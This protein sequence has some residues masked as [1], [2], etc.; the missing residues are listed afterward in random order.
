MATQGT[1]NVMV[2]KLGIAILR[3]SSEDL[4]KGIRYLADCAV[5]VLGA[6]IERNDPVEVIDTTI[7]MMARDLVDASYAV[8][9]GKDG[10]ID[11]PRGTI[12]VKPD[13]SCYTDVQ[14]KI[15]RIPYEA[16]WEDTAGKFNVQE[17]LQQAQ[18]RRMPATTV[19]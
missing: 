18:L 8:E 19:H 7:I 17:E 16:T 4:N 2:G 5:S 9:A 11:T 3:A 10:R 13:G 6:A 14:G 15:N 12:I 1:K